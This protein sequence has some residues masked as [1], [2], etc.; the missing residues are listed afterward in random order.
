MAVAAAVV[1]FVGAGCDN[2]NKSSNNG[3]STNKPPSGV[4]SV[5]GKYAM[6]QGGAAVEWWQFNAD[7]TFAMFNDAGFTS[8]HVSGTYTQ[9]GNIIQGPFQIPAGKGDIY[10]VLSADGKTMSLDFIEHW[11]SPDKHNPF[12]GVKL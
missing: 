12:N 6:N 4:N 1:L 9:N 2:N 3:G 7:G 10:C 5:V 11:H 8:Q